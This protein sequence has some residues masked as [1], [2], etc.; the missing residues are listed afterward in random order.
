MFELTVEGEFAAAHRIAG[1]AGACAQLHGHNYRVV[2]V[3]EGEALDELGMLVDFAVLR[4][5]LAAVTGELDHRCL[6]EVPAL[7][8]ANPTSE[9]LARHIY[10]ALAKRLQEEG[11]IFRVRAV[12]VQESARSGATYRE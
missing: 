11:V 5:A 3:V 9:Q 2:A 10:Q 12:T 6:N 8:G 1:H 4:Q 7:A